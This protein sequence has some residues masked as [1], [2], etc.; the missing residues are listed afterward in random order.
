MDY[1]KVKKTQDKHIQLRVDSITVFYK[2][3]ELEHVCLWLEE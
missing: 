2:K 3:D 1:A